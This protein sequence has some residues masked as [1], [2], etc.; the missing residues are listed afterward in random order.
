M[1]TTVMVGEKPKV[2]S[3]IANALG[4]YSMKENRGVKNYII[5][6]DERRLIVAPAVGHIFNLDQVSEGWD[7][8]VFDVEW[9]PTFETDDSAGY[10]KKYYNNLRDQL[11]KADTYINAC[12][13]DL[14]GSVIGANVIKQIT[15]A[16]DEKIERMKFSTLTQSDLRDAYDNL[17]SFDRGMTSAGIAR[18]ILDYYYGVNVSRALM[19]AVRENDRYK[20][21]S[22]GRVQGPALKVLADKEREIKEF[23]PDPYWE[24]YLHHNEFDAKLKEPE[25][26]KEKP[27][28]IWDEDKANQIFSTVEGERKAKVR[29]IKINNYKHNPPIPFNLTGLQKEASSQFNL[30][31][32]KTQSI[33]QSLYED[34]LISYP[35]TESQK[36]PPKLGYKNL[37][38]DLKNQE[39]YENLAKRVLNKDK[40]DNL[41]PKQG[42]KKDDA[43]PCFKPDAKVSFNQSARSFSDIAGEV[44]N[45]EWDEEK[46]SYFGEIDKS[47]VISHDSHVKKSEVT[48]I[49]RTP[50]EGDLLDVETNSREVSVTP[51]HRFLTFTEEGLDYVEAENLREKDIVFKQK[52]QEEKV[53]NLS[54]NIEL[55]SAFS[56]KHWE[57]I[58][59][60]EECSV[61]ETYDRIKEF[62]EDIEIGKAEKLAAITGF[63]FGDGHLR[64]EKPSE[65][66]E[67]YP[68]VHFTGRIEDMKKLKEDIEEVGFSAYI[69]SDEPKKAMI[70]SKNSA[71]GRLLIALG[72][73][74]GDKMTKNFSVPEWVK[75]DE[76]LKREFLAGIFGAE[77]TKVRTHTNN[78]RDIRNLRFEQNKIKKLEESF[79]DFF[80][81]LMQMCEDLEI[82]TSNL[83]TAKKTESRKK[84]GEKTVRGSFSI[85]NNRENL[86]KFVNKIPM[87]YS[88]YKDELR[89]NASAYLAL[90]KSVIKRRKSKRQKAKK[91]YQNGKGYKEIGEE[92][93]ISK[94]TVK[95]WV[96]YGNGGKEEHVPSEEIPK[97][98]EFNLKTPKQTKPEIINKIE[99]SHY[100]GHVYD[101][102][103]EENH[104]YFAN[105]LLVH[106]C[107]YP[108]GKH[109]SGLSKMEKKVYDL[110]V[111]RF[112]A[113]FGEAAKRQS[114]TLTLDVLGYSFKAKSK[115]TK[116]RNWFSLYDPYVNVEEA[117]L[118]EV[119]EGEKLDVEDFSLEDK[120]TKPPRRYSQ[121]RIVSELEKKNL[122]T[123]ATRASTIDR[124][125]DRNYIEGSPIEVTQLG[126]T[127]V[128]TLEKHAPDVLS[129][130]LTRNFEEK[131]ES[132]KQGEKSSEEV[133]SEA[134]EELEETL[135]EFKQKEKQIG[136]ELVETIDKERNRQRRLGE[137]QECEDGTLKIIKNNG[138]RFVGCSN[139]PDCENSFPLPSNG[140]IEGMDEA[141][142]ECGN[143]KIYVSRNSG[144]DYNMCIYPDCPTKDDW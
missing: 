71:F 52:K 49:W 131:M 103:V 92:I 90:R 39:K 86:E 36:L 91:M 28:R 18:H 84:D 128:N 134:Q 97:F 59:E 21:L 44:D 106:N 75:K 72:C 109:P 93:N 78:G 80:K 133:V 110:I 126:L 31:P 83:S 99:T 87:R 1:Q 27:E 61:N 25:E 56:K 143:P 9:K 132:I 2:T 42:K 135:T 130:E 112:F 64:F 118:P 47:G 3:K 73:P 13:F 139:Y 7:Y 102:E 23:E 68:Q 62:L 37:L 82:Q 138:S 50:Y 115:V 96:Y 116:Q 69:S 54:N 141:C 74:T 100:E 12:D 51:K 125:Y 17:E 26:D 38:K 58:Q 43:H 53:L 108:T 142:D 117:D 15:D 34:S 8:P 122:G 136:S 32:K 30:S 88:K 48:G 144:N 10:M 22:T 113:V 57:Q 70:A 63:C 94:Y 41:Y 79:K 98:K 104:N 40:R 33:A 35:R 107:I 77:L 127:I 76:N 67:K 120:E 4:D 140:D 121:S 81:E 5:E 137:C 19:Q 129:E 65:S 119:E 14:E 20:T 24:I 124:L 16:S 105:Q 60:G 55:E 45:W 101:I 95:S 11:E 89:R 85:K 6:T 111:K 123:K 29:D 114:L 46:E 66:R